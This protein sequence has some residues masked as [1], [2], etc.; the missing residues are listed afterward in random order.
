MRGRGL[1]LEVVCQ[2]YWRRCF[3]TCF[4]EGWGISLT[5]PSSFLQMF[6][7]RCTVRLHERDDDRPKVLREDIV[8]L[9]DSGG[10]RGER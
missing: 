2:V 1:L 4:A 7:P 10:I 6:T 9:A 5:R 8:D 3:S